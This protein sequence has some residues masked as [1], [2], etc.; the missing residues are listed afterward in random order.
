MSFCLTRTPATHI[1]S[2][3]GRNRTAGNDAIEMQQHVAAW[4]ENCAVNMFTTK[5]PWSSIGALHGR[6]L[7]DATIL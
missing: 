4:I 6:E 2:V 1:G 5:D 3:T 7:C